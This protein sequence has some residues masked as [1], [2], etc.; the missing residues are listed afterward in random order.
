MLVLVMGMFVGCNPSQIL[1]WP[2]TVDPDVACVDRLHRVGLAL[3]QYHDIY[4]SFPPISVLDSSGQPKHC[5]RALLLPYLDDID[6]TA[7]QY[8]PDHPFNHDDNVA[9]AAHRP[10]SLGCPLDHGAHFKD[11]SFVLVGDPDFL[12]DAGSLQ[13][14]E[15]ITDDPARTIIVAE[16]HQNETNWLEA[17]QITF[18]QFLTLRSFPH[19]ARKRASTEQHMHLLMADGS[20]RRLVASITD[21]QLRALFTIASGDDA[22][23]LPVMEISKR[24]ARRDTSRATP[25]KNAAPASNSIESAPNNAADDT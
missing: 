8:D 6:G 2:R 13:G 17:E 4:D 5:W 11:S 20:V 7:I 14:L 15:D 10:E 1:P 22:P 3:L 9:L 24:Q 12:F 21:D 16:L 25:A 18:P 23:R 19:P